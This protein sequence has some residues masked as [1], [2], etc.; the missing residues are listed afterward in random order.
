MKLI[1]GSP[2]TK[3]SRLKTKSN[4]AS[5]TAVNDASVK[6][7]ALECWRIRKAVER[8]TDRR[9]Q[10]QIRTS[11]EKMIGA[12]ADSGI[13]I[14][15]PEGMEYNDGMMLNIAVFDLDEKLEMGRR[16]V[17]E[18]LSPNVYINNKLAHTARVIVSVGARTNLPGA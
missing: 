4:L 18:T 2:P 14:E 17:S 3:R 5:V 15:D 9:Q 13:S 7:L 8:S 16:V 10:F 1:N 6:A 12:L 11:V